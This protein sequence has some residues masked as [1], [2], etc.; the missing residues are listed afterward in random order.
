MER[1]ETDSAFRFNGAFGEFLKLSLAN[2][3]LTLVTLGIYRFWATVRERQFFW[4]RTEFIDDTLEWAG[5]GKELFIGFLFGFVLFAIPFGVITLI[6]QGL[7]L[8]D[9]KTIAG[10]LIAVVYLVLM[11]LSG[12]AVFRGLRYRLSRTYW[13]GIHGGTDNPGFRYG[14][15]YLWRQVLALVS[16]GIFL[17]WAQTRL[18]RERW[19]AMSFGPHQ[20]ESNAKFGPLMGLWL[21][22]YVVPVVLFFVPLFFWVTITLQGAIIDFTNPSTFA[23]LAFAIALA[24]FFIYIIWPLI[25]LNYYARY[26][27]H[28]VG[29][30]GIAGLEFEFTATTRHWLK[31][32]I[33]NFGLY[34]IAYALALVPLWLFGLLEPLKDAQRLVLGDNIFTLVAIALALAVPMGMARAIARYRTWRFFIGHMEALGEIDLAGLTQ[35]Q[36]RTMTQGEGLLD[37][38]DMGAI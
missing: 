36:T 21:L 37:A 22:V 20:F 34:V 24:F 25:A 18:W 35:S 4:G 32:Y 13:H 16:L 17:P 27:Q 3:G 23:A 30:M 5:T 9:E 1:D 6:G 29:T 7:I 11:A 15:N 28:V 10:I 33:G 14:L 12:F 19:T 2:L 38:L 8:R 31:L 26:T